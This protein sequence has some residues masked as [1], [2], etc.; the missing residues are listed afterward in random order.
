[1]IKIIRAYTTDI[2]ALA[3]VFILIII[4]NGEYIWGNR[5][6]G[7]FTDTVNM[8][9]PLFSYI[10]AVWIDG[11]IPLW[12]ESILGG[13]EMYN[14]PMV[15]IIYPFYFWGLLD[16]GIEVET[17]NTIVRV[18]VFH[19]FIHAL[20]VFILGK[21]LKL[22][23]INSFL[24][25]LLYMSSA[26]I[27]LSIKWVN[28]F[29]SSAWMPWFLVALYYLVNHKKTLP[30]ILYFS[31]AL[32]GMTASPTS[33]FS[34]IYIG[35][36]VIGLAM[37]FKE[38]KF[39]IIK[40]CLILV[41]VA[42]GLTGVSLIPILLE[43]DNFLRFVGH[44]NPALV[45]AQKVPLSSYIPQLSISH[46][47]DFFYNPS[48]SRYKKISHPYVGPIAFLFGILGIVFLIK[49][50]NLKQNWF[51][52]ALLL[53]A[54]LSFLAAHGTEFGFIK[55]IYKMPLLDKMRHPANHI[56]WFMIVIIFF[57]CYALQELDKITIKKSLINTNTVSYAIGIIV[58]IG[59][60]ISAYYDFKNQHLFIAIAAVTVVILFILKI[61][62]YK[63]IP[64]FTIGATLLALVLFF[65]IPLKRTNP[66]QYAYNKKVHIE[67]M[68]VLKKLNTK[69]NDKDEYRVTY[70][71]KS[72]T[73]GKWSMNAS[74]FGFRSFQGK[75][76]PLPAD[77]FRE[78]FK[79]DQFK[80]YRL[81]NG[82]KWSIRS[83]EKKRK[84]SILILSSKNYEVF[85]NDFAYPRLYMADKIEKFEGTFR[86]FLE[87]TNKLDI[88]K[89]HVFLGKTDFDKVLEIIPSTIPITKAQLSS[90]SRTHNTF[91]YNI[92][93]PE[94]TLFVWNEF[95]NDN[96]WK[97]YI[98]GKRANIFRANFNQIGFIVP[99]G[100]H[101]IKI[102][103]S[104]T[105]FWIFLQLRRIT[106]LIL[107]VVFFFNCWTIT[108][109]YYE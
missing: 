103:Y 38:N 93:T 72:Y 3:I 97:I 106:I 32:V 105:I 69:V 71:T 85:E 89:R 88:T 19:L 31:L 70:H 28:W 52:Y 5:L 15:S 78:S 11:E 37:I 98:N 90:L 74:Y 50:N 42:I 35:L 33:M 16:Y 61:Y 43:S 18:K 73:D 65:N 86:N 64:S 58:L 49:R 79:N 104:H 48:L 46:L 10:S 66:R 25:A 2:I 60:Y 94:Q 92:D 17:M 87:E 8:L 30:S 57:S 63:K 13:M 102:E 68:N 12:N 9:A 67:S 108:K 99:E 81:M 62:K 24:M 41:V 47:S 107:L 53:I 55:V 1:M 83:K 6:Y 84:N 34:P 27:L 82:A 100:K 54:I 96:N 75:V 36:L 21:T 20:G 51:K 39:E 80:N 22:N 26:Y 44:G 40:R 14:A 29:A 59:V 101:I 7:P 76:V 109:H 4:H 91:F 45:G 56:Y 95:Y 77:Q 23:S